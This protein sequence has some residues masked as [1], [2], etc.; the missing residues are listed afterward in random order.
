MTL[1]REHPAD[2]FVAWQGEPINGVQHPPE[3]ETIW[4]AAELAACNLFVPK[5]ADPVPAGKVITSTLVQRVTGVQYV[6]VTEDAPVLR[7]LVRK[8]TVQGRLIDAGLMVA[9]YTALTSNPV[10]FARWFAPDRPEVYADD[11]DALTFLNAIGAD[12][13][14][15]LAEDA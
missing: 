3:I 9:A 7:R 5:P 6:H 10:Y 2:V 12:P 4:S 14:V 15:I 13:S 8:S 11:V 1:Y